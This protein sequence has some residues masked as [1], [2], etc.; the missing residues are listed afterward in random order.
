MKPRTRKITISPLFA[1]T[2]ISENT[3]EPAVAYDHR[4]R[5]Y[6]NKQ[7]YDKA[8]EDYTEAIRLDPRYAVAYCG[9]GD[10][11]RKK[12]EYDKAIEDY[13]EAI[14]LDP[15]YEFLYPI[16]DRIG[17]VPNLAVAYNNRGDTYFDKQEMTKP[18]RTTP[19]LSDSPPGMRFPPTVAGG[20]T[21]R[22]K[23]EYDKAI[24]DY[25]K[26]IEDYT[27]AIRP[28]P[29]YEILY[30]IGDRIGLVSF[31]SC[32]CLQ[33][34]GG[35]LPKEE[36]IR[37]SHRGLHRCYPTLHP[38]DAVAYRTGGRVTNKQT[39]FIRPWRTT[40]RPVGLI[41]LSTWL[42]TVRGISPRQ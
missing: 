22:K 35:H 23:K 20:H 16:G 34:P 11:Y 36:R 33:Q 17:F 24:E 42:A 21:Y 1:S 4:G 14:R 31:E 18:S 28:A 41:P 7:E 12:K 37:Q 39:G 27:E 2:H 26:A 5:A 13:T 15:R 29:R 3:P 10:T 32:G 9:R 38:K 19:R 25:T 6:F 40:L 8:I 30:P